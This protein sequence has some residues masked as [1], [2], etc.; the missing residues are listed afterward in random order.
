MQ[1][2][3]VEK[4]PWER[5]W[6]PTPVFLPGKSHGQRSL[7]ATVRGVAESLTRPSNNNK[8]TPLRT[9]YVLTVSGSSRYHPSLVISLYTF[10]FFYFLNIFLFDFLTLQYCI[11]L[12]YIKMNLPQVYMCSPSWTLLPP[13]SPFHPSGSRW[14]YCSESQEY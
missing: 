11:G 5:K 6:Q 13:P 2:I 4:I 1:E 8:D 7:A 12:P 9:L 14:G 3:W 10:Y